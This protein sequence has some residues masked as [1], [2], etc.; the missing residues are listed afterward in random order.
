M[1]FEPVLDLG[2]RVLARFLASEPKEKR[3]NKAGANKWWRG[4]IVAVGAG[5]FTYD[6][7]YDDKVIEQGV[8]ARFVQRLDEAEPIKEP[9][10]PAWPVEPMERA[11]VHRYDLAASTEHGA[12]AGL[13][14][15]ASSDLQ[16]RGR[17]GA[18]A[19]VDEK[20]LGTPRQA[21]DLAL[22]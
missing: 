17:D 1:S 5:G 21:P 3:R 16:G 22:T 8:H 6:V 13:R 14:P 18:G 20:K 9:K 7:E 4:T 15:R 19:P 11:K 12:A 2:M 10:E